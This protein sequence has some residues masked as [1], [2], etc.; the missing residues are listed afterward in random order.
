MTITSC[1]VCRRNCDPFKYGDTL[2]PKLRL[3]S[4]GTL[5]KYFTLLV[6]TICAA[7]LP[8]N[9][10]LVHS[11]H[12][13]SAHAEATSKAQSTINKAELINR[14]KDFASAATENAKEIGAFVTGPAWFKRD[15]SRVV[16]NILTTGSIKTHY[17]HEELKG[18]LKKLREA[19]A[20]HG[21][22][23]AVLFEARGCFYCHK[24]NTEI[25]VRPDI[26]RLL[27]RE[28]ELVRVDINSY[29]SI[30]DLDGG[31]MTETT[32]SKHWNVTGTPTMIFF[33]ANK[34]AL[35]GNELI[36]SRMSGVHDPEKIKEL[37]Y[38]V[39]AHGKD[40]DALTKLAGF[41]KLENGGSCSSGGGFNPFS[42]MFSTVQKIV[43]SAKSLRAKLASNE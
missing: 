28:F 34:N 4:R 40:P 6:L 14:A 3:R 5:M 31:Q 22:K 20:P 30:V 26:K 15:K 1:K 18:N 19:A 7:Y 37:L 9:D 35:P 36:L 29:A 23:L 42:C 8:S 27:D 41:R 11:A 2:R 25:L 24:L 33:P 43:L 39:S 10:Y 13:Q 21:K 32:L 38:K 17:D 12:A 16:R